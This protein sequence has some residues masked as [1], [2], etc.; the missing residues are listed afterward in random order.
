MIISR[1][2]PRGSLREKYRAELSVINKKPFTNISR[3][4]DWGIK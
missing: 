2:A 3:S 4:L 1:N